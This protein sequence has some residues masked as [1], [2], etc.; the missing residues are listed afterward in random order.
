MR[1]DS[2]PGTS[3]SNEGTY[4]HAAFIVLRRVMQVFIVIPASVVG[5]VLI[6]FGA[7]GTGTRQDCLAGD[8][9]L[10]RGVGAACSA[11]GRPGSRLWGGA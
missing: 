4:L 3:G 2:K 6:F 1:S 9:H 11:G 7:H 5:A 8:T 10:G